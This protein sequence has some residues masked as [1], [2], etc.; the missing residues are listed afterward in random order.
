MVKDDKFD[1]VTKRTIQEWGITRINKSTSGKNF[2][3]CKEAMR[4]HVDKYLDLEIVG[5]RVLSM[6]KTFNMKKGDAAS[7]PPS[8]N[9]VVVGL[10]W[11]SKGSVDFDASVV[12]LDAG[13]NKKDIIFYGKKKGSGIF[14]R[15]DNTTGAGSGD[16]E[17]I[18]I[19][20]D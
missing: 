8:A 17:R 6:E 2:Q 13:M 4:T 20:F 14:H 15:G 1:P 19:N 12:C 5:E 10:G 16:D 3:E 7:L 11:T 9:S 18:K